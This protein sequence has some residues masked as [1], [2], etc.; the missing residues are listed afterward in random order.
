MRKRH[1][2]L[3]DKAVHRHNARPDKFQVGD[4]VKIWN[5]K[6]KR[7]SEPA[8]IDS[9]IAGDDMM[10]RSYKVILDNGRVRHVAAAWLLRAAAE[11]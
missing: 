7:Y 2:E 8:V 4:S 3:R 5:P 9:P 6:Q 10:P 1:Q 11:E